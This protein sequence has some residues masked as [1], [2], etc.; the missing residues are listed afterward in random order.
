[1]YVLYGLIML[2]CVFIFS[3]ARHR[4]LFSSRICYP[5]YVYFI[6]SYIFTT[7]CI[8]FPSRMADN[9]TFLLFVNGS[10][11]I[12]WLLVYYFIKSNILL[13]KFLGKVL[14]FVKHQISSFSSILF[15]KSSLFYLHNVKLN[16]NGVKDYHTSRL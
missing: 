11:R 10:F 4:L 12:Y 8:S 3:I 13:N 9:I 2:K 16:Y 15:S 6:I 1:M 14:H 7:I 5:N